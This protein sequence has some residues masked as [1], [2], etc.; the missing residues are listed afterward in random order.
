MLAVLLGAGVA[1][2]SGGL[3]CM[4][5]TDDIRA[6]AAYSD[7]Q[8]GTGLLIIQG[9]RTIWEDY[10]GVGGP[11]K[12]GKIYSGTKLFWNLAALA[13]VEDGLLLMKER[14]ATTLGEWQG[15]PQKSRIT[16]RQLLDFSCG[17]DPAF[18]LHGDA[19]RDRD[20]MAIGRPLVA[21]PG[22]EF[23]YGPC[24][25]QVFHEVLKRKLAA[26]GETPTAY[27]ERRV[28]R[29]L[30]LGPQRYLADGA[31]NPLLASGF[32][33]TAREWAR[34]GVLLL[35][36]GQPI[37]VER[38]LRESFR[39]SGANAAFGLGLWNNAGS[40]R[41]G[42]RDEDA[43][44][45]EEMLERDWQDQRWGGAFLCRSA[46]KD[47]LASI[48]SMGQRLYV[49]P[50]LDL[51]IVRMGQAAKFSDPDFLRLLFPGR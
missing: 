10:V 50:S 3:W 26:R 8:R 2:A 16:I 24:A 4:P 42:A 31:G 39:G 17:L 18:E 14:V 11:D 40:R 35:R 48:G 5:S 51:V 47:L 32:M 13:A 19:I 30:G 21:A 22:R 34:A 44:D 15:D 29:P 43:V 23:I 49:V 12:P 36:G 25:L 37:L 33:L 38:E 45:I 41:W 20:A 46:P 27:L 1:A 28:L 6:A 9:G 7:A